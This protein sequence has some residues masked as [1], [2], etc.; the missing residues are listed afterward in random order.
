MHKKKKLVFLIKPM[1]AVEGGSFIIE[2]VI[3][4]V[5]RPLALM[6]VHT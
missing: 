5:T 1:L 3:G 4:C 6:R 2:G